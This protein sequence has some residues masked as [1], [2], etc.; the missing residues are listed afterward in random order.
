[1]SRGKRPGLSRWVEALCRQGRARESQTGLGV[2]DQGG[3][4][5]EIR[6]GLHLGGFFFSKRNL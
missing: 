4:E 1:M 6:K 3:Q 2:G 5:A